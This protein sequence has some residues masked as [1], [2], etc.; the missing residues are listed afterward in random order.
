MHRLSIAETITQ[1]R[2]K[3][4]SSCELTQHYLERIQKYEHLN[5]YISSCAEKALEQA[6]ISDQKLAND[7]AGA[8][9]GVPLA[10][11]DLFVTKGVRTTA[12]SKML[13]NF[14][15]PYESSV[16]EKLRRAGAVFLG[17]TN[18]DEFAMGSASVTSSFGPVVNPW[19]ASSR[20]NARDRK[21]VV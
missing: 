12:G 15:P 4:I 5:S 2:S 20:P 3:K 8:L 6:Q 1:L 9:E 16:T 10:I 11:K 21:S 13:H 7:T 17:K 14:V 19:K 18:M